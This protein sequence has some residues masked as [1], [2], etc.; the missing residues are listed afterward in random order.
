[1]DFHSSPIV[2]TTSCGLACR[3]PQT[4]SASAIRLVEIPTCRFAL[5]D[6]E[7]YQP[8]R[9]LHCCRRRFGGRLLRRPSLLRFE[10]L[11]RHPLQVPHQ[12]EHFHEPQAIVREVDFPPVETLPG[13]V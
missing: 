4:K 13:R 7:I 11:L 2:K 1:M 5:A 10:N 8:L 6:C 9:P 12:A 3:S